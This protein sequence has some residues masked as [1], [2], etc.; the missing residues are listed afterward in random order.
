M[1]G[2]L[3]LSLEVELVDL[4]AQM[5]DDYRL[6]AEEADRLW[7]IE[8]NQEATPED[9]S[10]ATVLESQQ[11][12]EQILHD[13]VSPFNRGPVARKGLRRG[14]SFAQFPARGPA[15]KKEAFETESAVDRLLNK[16]VSP[17][18]IMNFDDLE[19]H[20]KLGLGSK[21]ETA[22]PQST[23][24][25]M[26]TSDTSS[27]GHSKAPFSTLSGSSLPP[28]YL[29]GVSMTFASPKSDTARRP[30]KSNSEGPRPSSY[31]HLCGHQSP[32]E[33]QRVVCR[34]FGHTLCKKSVCRRCFEKNEWDFQ[35][36]RAKPWECT[37]C[38]G[39]CPERSQCTTY[40]RTNQERK[41]KSLR[42]SRATRMDTST[43]SF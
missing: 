12:Q 26:D 32:D 24:D 38:R 27:R 5:E 16:A 2:D 10:M 36:A 19:K 14:T 7:S 9:A 23:D 8:K 21:V 33:F 39:C 17:A 4:V 22:E 3:R 11:L 34:N 40:N 18:S 30:K 29:M 1:A 41:E 37:H 35:E 6:L 28:G 15:V 42:G 31:C 13:T 43:R 20:S 25:P